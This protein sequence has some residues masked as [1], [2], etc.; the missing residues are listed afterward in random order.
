MKKVLLVLLLVAAFGLF[1]VRAFAEGEGT[2][3]CSF[4]FQSLG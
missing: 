1:G 4:S 3:K 2:G